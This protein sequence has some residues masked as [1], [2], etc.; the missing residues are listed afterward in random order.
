VVGEIVK[1]EAQVG[2][3]HSPEYRYGIADAKFS[4]Q[5]KF[6]GFFF[7]GDI[8]SDFYFICFRIVVPFHPTEHDLYK[9]CQVSLENVIITSKYNH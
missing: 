6:F 8:C 2:L 9:F 7:R 1:Q 5:P 4:K 3:Y